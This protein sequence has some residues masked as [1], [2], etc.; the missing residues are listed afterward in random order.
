MAPSAC[1]SGQRFW[2]SC[3]WPRSGQACS[4]HCPQN[5]PSRGLA[6][7]SQSPG[8]SRGTSS[9][10]EQLQT[11]Q[12]NTM[13]SVFGELSTPPA[14]VPLIPL[15]MRCRATLL[16]APQRTPALGGDLGKEGFQ[17]PLAKDQHL[18]GSRSA[19]NRP[20]LRLCSSR[21]PESWSR[22]WDASAE[23]RDGTLGN[24]ELK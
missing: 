4:C 18:A 2:G 20:A 7:Q 12:R 10:K 19:G 5:L 3:L 21:D 16:G 14:C 15:Q 11:G 24:H 1:R 17:G 9:P 13:V 23:P 6:P 8:V 22:G